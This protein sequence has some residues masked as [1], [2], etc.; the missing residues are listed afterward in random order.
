[1]TFP[2]LLWAHQLEKV[3][4]A[5]STVAL[6]PGALSS[7]WGYRSELRSSLGEILL[8][9]VP[10]FLGGVLGA[11]LLLVTS[12]ATFARLVPYLILLA[13]LLFIVQEPLTRWQRRRAKLVGRISN[14]S[15][16]SGRIEN[17]SYQSAPR[18]WPRWAAV[19]VF[20]F[21]VGVYGGYFGAGIGILMLAA[22]GLLGFTNIHHMNA[23]KNLNAMFINGIAAVVFIV[24]SQIG[25]ERLVDWRLA[26]FMAA[27]AIVGGYAGAGGARRIGQKNV[28]RLVILIGLSLTA[29]L[30]A[31]QF[32]R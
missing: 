23:L 13:T 3:A 18:S 17:P 4:N 1:L 21:F 22:F 28:R 24:K 16:F 26:M 25:P 14:P 2:A 20:Q 5:T 30:L 32:R 12:N 15:T 9:S 29:V 6:W 8:L 19:L 27:A 10:S 7:F 11:M 31:R